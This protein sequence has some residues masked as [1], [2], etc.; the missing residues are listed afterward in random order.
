[1]H[2]LFMPM[3]DITGRLTNSDMKEI[4][5]L[6][7][8]ADAEQKQKIIAMCNGKSYDDLYGNSYGSIS[9]NNTNY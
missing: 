4:Y 6:I 9:T 2:T 5:K 8:Y 7:L 3:R 1:M